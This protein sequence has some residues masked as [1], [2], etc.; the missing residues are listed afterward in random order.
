MATF[1]FTPDFSAQ[2]S[3][4]PVV[5]AVKFGDGYEQRL[6]YGINNNPKQWSLT[7]AARDDSEANSIEAFFDARGGVESFD[8][9]APN[10]TY[11][12]Y[13]CREWNRTFDK[14]NL[15]TVTASFEQ[16][17]DLG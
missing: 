8:W 9:T 16:V 10:G 5:R 6:A 7:F 12:K 1:N 11:G 4:R 2:V 3:S 15:N 17:Y 13:V 14:S